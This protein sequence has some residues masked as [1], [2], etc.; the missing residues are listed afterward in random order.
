[1]RTWPARHGRATRHGRS[2][3]SRF[4][5]NGCG[6]ARNSRFVD[7]GDAIDQG[8]ARWS[9]LMNHYA[10]T[11]LPIITGHEGDLIKIEVI[12]PRRRACVML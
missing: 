7:R 3:A 12:V 5:D 10:G 11:M 2:V 1:M 4:A 6:L 8:V 9:C